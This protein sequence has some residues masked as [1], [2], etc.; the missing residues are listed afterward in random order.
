[1][2]AALALVLLLSILPPS[3]RDVYSTIHS[4]V[5]GEESANHFHWQV[6]DSLQKVG[7]QPGDKIA[8]IGYSFVA[9]W[10]RL[11]RVQIIAEL[12]ER[13]RFLPI[14]DDNLIRSQAVDEFWKADVSVR[15]RAVEAFARTGAKIIVAENIPSTANASGW[16]RIGTT[17]YYFYTLAR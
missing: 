11:A 17:D 5:K 3:L 8:Y 2:A 10:A 16:E 1:L 13:N 7:V 15:N 4:I 9:S 12:P 6:A 14:D